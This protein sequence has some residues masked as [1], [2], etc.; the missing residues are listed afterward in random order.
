MTA[1]Q[2]GPAAGCATCAELLR[3]AAAAEKAGD[4]SKAVDYRVLLRRHRPQ[5]GGEPSSAT[6]RRA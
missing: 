1:P 4:F 3:A 5:H 2:T 6:G